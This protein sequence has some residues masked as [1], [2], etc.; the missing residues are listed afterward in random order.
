VGSAADAGDG[1]P[2]VLPGELAVLT[3]DLDDTLY[4]IGPVVGEA[5][6]AMVSAM[7]SLLPDP[8]AASMITEGALI[9]AMVALRRALA[10]RPITYTDLR[11][12][13]AADIFDQITWGGGPGEPSGAYGTNTPMSSAWAARSFG[14]WLAERNAAATRWMFPGAAASLRAI[15]EKYPGVAIGA[16]TNGRGHPDDMIDRDRGE[17][18]LRGV[19]DFVVCGDEPEVFPFRKPSTKIYEVALERAGFPGGSWDGSTGSVWIHV[20]DNLV[21]DVGASAK[22]GATAVLVDGKKDERAAV[23]GGDRDEI[24]STFSPEE[25]EWRRVAEEEAKQRVAATV[26]NIADLPDIIEQILASLP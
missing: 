19:F 3:F 2:V 26:E 25:K 21:N 5:D 14:V 13:A 9:D 17:A 12:R 16:V 20:G 24:W 23:A 15:R 10:G 11:V 18:P 1:V 4:P 22:C 7:R 8:A 6:A